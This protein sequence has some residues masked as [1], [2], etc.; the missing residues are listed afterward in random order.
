AFPLGSVGAGTGA[1]TARFKGGLGSA[2]AVL[3][4]GHVTGAL[5]AVNALGDATVD[6]RHFW[7]APFE[8]DD[9]FG[10]FGPAATYPAGVPPTKLASHA[11]NTT[12]AIV[13]TDADLDQ[14]QCTRLATAAH[15]GMAR[16]LVP[17]HSPM[18]GDLVYGVATGARP[19]HDPIAD[20]L[21]IG[22]AAATCLARA[23]ARAV[24]HATPAPGDNHP[25]YRR[26]P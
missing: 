21:L 24:W 9:E 1:T 20:T 3:P 17:S 15:D 7:A 23:I 8:E 25:C 18:D 19:L 5:V 16:A 4:S 6:G 13:A 11:A 22:H 2:S 26:Q 14:A 12:I 10:G